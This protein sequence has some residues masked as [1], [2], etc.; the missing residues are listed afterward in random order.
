MCRAA[1]ALVAAL[2][3]HLRA[4]Q[5]RCPAAGAELSP[6]AAV[7][8]RSPCAHARNTC[9]LHVLQLGL[10]PQE[11]CWVAAGLGGACCVLLKHASSN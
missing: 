8:V 6:E 2:T 4:A 10:V 5:Q 1:A 11:H 3:A 7:M 9:F